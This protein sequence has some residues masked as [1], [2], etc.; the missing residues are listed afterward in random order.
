MSNKDKLE[1]IKLLNLKEKKLF[2][3]YN[4]RAP[5]NVKVNHLTELIKVITELDTLKVITGTGIKR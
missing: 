3:T 4:W 5:A 2:E 1:K